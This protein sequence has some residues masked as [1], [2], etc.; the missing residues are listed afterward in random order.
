MLS[1]TPQGD[2]AIGTSSLGARALLTLTLLA[3]LEL[4]PAWAEPPDARAA[5]LRPVAITIATGELDQARRLLAAMV[6]P[7]RDVAVGPL[8]RL[9]ELL[10][11]PTAHVEE[12][13]TIASRLAQLPGRDDGV[14]A[15]G[16]ALLRLWRPEIESAQWAANGDRLLADRRYREALAAYQR[17]GQRSRLRHARREAVA[18]CRTGIADQ[19]LAA[20][21][22]AAQ[23]LRH[24][25]AATLAREAKAWLP[26]EERAR[27]DALIDRCAQQA[28]VLGLVASSRTAARAG[29]LERALRLARAAAL[30]RGEAGQHAREQLPWLIEREALSRA[31]E[32]YQA[33]RGR[34]ALESLR[35]VEGRAA[36]RL[37]ARIR[38]VMA[39]SLRAQQCSRGEAA[40]LWQRLL[41]CEPDRRNAYVVRAQ[42]EVE[43]QVQ[44]STTSARSLDAHTD[45]LCR[46][47][48]F[49]RRASRLDPWRLDH[50]QLIGRSLMLDPHNPLAELLWA[51]LHH[52]IRRR[53]A[54]NERRFEL[55]GDAERYLTV[56]RWSYRQLLAAGP[57]RDR[58]NDR[59]VRRI[60]QLGGTV[61]PRDPHPRWMFAS[62]AQLGVDSAE[63]RRTRALA[64]ARSASLSASSRRD[65]A[66]AFADKVTIEQVK[67]GRWGDQAGDP[68]QIEL[69]FRCSGRSPGPL[70]VV[71]HARSPS[72]QRFYQRRVVLPPD[73]GTPHRLV[74]VYDGL[75]TLRYGPL[76][77]ARVEIHLGR[78]VDDNLLVAA[79]A[80]PAP[81]A[82]W[83]RPARRPVLLGH[84]AAGQNPAQSDTLR[85]LE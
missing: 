44:A 7:V 15:L 19:L 71:F 48:I 74:A 64:L 3:S 47:S 1:I 60:R 56:A 61:P 70:T 55:D 77:Q 29:D 2:P 25:Y 58:L 52:E 78:D 17:I 63:L 51:D 54:A 35:S 13:V 34:Q 73:P 79:N 85:L 75:W 12:I 76:T 16:E 20:A 69:R 22:R 82:W 62:L 72:G 46:S 67:V 66:S 83:Q 39:L 84:A 36:A 10:R 38:R 68:R 42:L 59:L 32:R 27:A 40:G 24:T 14:D 65:D 50:A 81:D 11:R 26:A 30:D 4:R 53:Q 9:C 43:R 6:E 80:G 18:R 31:R 37:R 49:A 41:A 28:R 45:A 21:R 5:D 57:N 33:G 23:Q 8:R